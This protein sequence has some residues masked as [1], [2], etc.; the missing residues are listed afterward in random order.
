[1]TAP[2][3]CSELY[4]GSALFEYAYHSVVGYHSALDAVLIRHHR[5]ALVHNEIE[6]YALFIKIFDR[7]YC[8]VTGYFFVVGASDIDIAHG[9]ESLFY[10]LLYAFEYG[11]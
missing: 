9:R 11:A 10:K 1:M 5:A 8:A 7:F 3:P 4:V 6:M 2:A